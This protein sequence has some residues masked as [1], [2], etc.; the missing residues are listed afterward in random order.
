MIDRQFKVRL[1]NLNYVLGEWSCKYNSNLYCVEDGNS[2]LW[3]YNWRQYYI[4][5]EIGQIY[6][7]AVYGIHDKNLI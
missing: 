5:Q 7:A 2:Y 1:S 4:Y 6:K 3:A